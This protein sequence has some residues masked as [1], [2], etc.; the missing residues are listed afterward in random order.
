[1]DNDDNR[2]PPSM[3]VSPA[4]K[5]GVEKPAL[6]LRVGNRYKVMHKVGGGS[7]GDIFLGQDT[8][9]GG[10]VAIKLESATARHPQLVYE[11][12]VY[13]L[14]QGG[15]G[16]P[17]IYWYGA[18]DDYMCMVIDL[19]GP[20][21]EDLFTVCKRRFSLKTTLMIADQ[22]LNRAEY[23]HS[24]NF[25]HRD[26]KPDNFLIGTGSKANMV[27][28]I[29]F[30]L[31]KKYRD[32]KNKQH[33]PYRENKNLTGTARYTSV[34][35]HLGIEQARRDDLEGI[36]YVLIYFLRG[37]LPW[38]G[39]KAADKKEKYEKIM[40]KKMGTPL[41]VLCRDLPDEFSTYLQYCKNL[42]F[43]ERPDYSY[44]RRLF[45]D[46]FIREGFKFDYQF[47]WVGKNISKVKPQLG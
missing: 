12:R 46:L 9:T 15:V 34:N 5:S 29:D 36:G 35:T 47:D 42:R 10:Q 38:Q 39:L 16:I 28:M 32:S 25:L 7:F 22:M 26:V 37:N 33:I 1:M 14:V 40:R 41:E 13:K 21:L 43:E 6:E 27:Y 44:C 19:L 18:E 4:K 20:S 8:E 30:G 45:K 23:I 24:K 11:A 3:A 2:R 31:A 17:N